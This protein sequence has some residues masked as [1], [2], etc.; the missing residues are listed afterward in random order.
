MIISPRRACT[1]R[2]TVLGSQYLVRKCVCLSVTLLPCF[3]P[4]NRRNSYSNGFSATLPR[5][6]PT[7]NGVYRL[8][9]HLLQYSGRPRASACPAHQLEV[10]RMR[11]SP[12]VCNPWRACAARVTAC[13]SVCL[14]VCP[15][16]ISLHEH[17]I[18]P[19]KIP[20]IQRLVNVKMYVG[21][22]LKLLRSRVTA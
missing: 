18:A 20:R 9:C 5:S 17:L 1:A 2:V 16:A 4:R 13:L 15:R 6:D 7:T 14:S 12:R 11:S 3:L 10:S 21:F 19:Q 22:S 8:S